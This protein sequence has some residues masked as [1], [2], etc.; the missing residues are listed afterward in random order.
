LLSRAREA[1]PKVAIVTRWQWGPLWA[2][3]A[4]ILL[5]TLAVKAALPRFGAP[6]TARVALAGRHWLV[7]ARE[8]ADLRGALA[9][10]RA[11]VG[12]RLAELGAFV[13]ARPLRGVLVTCGPCEWFHDGLESE[14]ERRLFMIT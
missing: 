8:V 2:S 3:R 10:A 12:S 4:L 5:L 1:L 14:T 11:G 7:A 13:A 9:A 6:V